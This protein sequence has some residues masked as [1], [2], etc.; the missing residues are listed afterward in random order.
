M[1]LLQSMMPAS[2]LLTALLGAMPA[3]AEGVCKP[4]V[5]ISNAQFSKATNLKRYWT[6]TVTADASTCSASILLFSIRFL[7]WSESGP[8][9]E[10]IEPFI[11]Q[12]DE[13]VVRV[14]FRADEA[15]GNYRVYDV[16]TCPCREETR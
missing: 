9:I 2:A 16:S 8:D 14:E 13:H 12:R 7:R 1:S 15:V 3:S 10:F 6:A 5:E 11:R 4:K